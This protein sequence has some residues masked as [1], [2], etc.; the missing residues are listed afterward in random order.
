ME[1]Q[2]RS[3]KWTSLKVEFRSICRTRG[4]GDTESVGRAI[5][6]LPN[7]G[8][9]EFSDLDEKGQ[10]ISDGDRLVWTGRSRYWFSKKTNSVDKLQLLEEEKGPPHSLGLYF[11]FGMSVEEAKRD[12]DWQL[13]SEDD[14]KIVLRAK[15]RSRIPFGMS[16]DLT[17]DRK[18]FLPVSMVA[19]LNDSFDYRA[20]ST[21]CKVTHLEVNPVL[22]LDAIKNPNIVGWKLREYKEQ[23]LSPFW[24]FV[25]HSTL[26]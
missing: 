23:P 14:S 10:P 12:H 19:P 13:L 6:A 1:W 3:S 5:L 22:D 7:L 9:V 8:S 20:G 2:A 15:A 25:F 17:L 11:L 24:K 26:R 18:T 16:F 21:Q 4:F